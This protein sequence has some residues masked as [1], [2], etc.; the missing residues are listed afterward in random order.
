MQLAPGMGQSF[1]KL[2]Y[3]LVSYRAVLHTASTS[4][5]TIF[6]EKPVHQKENNGDI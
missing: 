6:C 2:G 1:A 3:F 5:G 4:N